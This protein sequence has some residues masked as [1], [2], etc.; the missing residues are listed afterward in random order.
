MHRILEPSCCCSCMVYA[1]QVATH[2]HAALKCEWIGDSVLNAD[3]YMV[4]TWQRGLLESAIGYNFE[5]LAE[6]ALYDQPR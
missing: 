6:C 4:L 1:A 2:M 5:I 3:T